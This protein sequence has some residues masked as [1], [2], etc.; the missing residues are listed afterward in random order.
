M[1]AGARVVVVGAG[2]GGSIVADALAERYA[3]TVIELGGPVT[4][5][6]DKI[7]DV[8]YPARLDPHVG[9][10]PGG[11]TGL[12]HNGLIEIDEDVFAERWPFPKAEL[13]P[14]YE[15]AY[16]LLSGATRAFVKAAGEG[17]RG[18]Y[19]DAG[20][21]VDR[22]P[23][24]FVP[25][26][27]RNL[28]HALGVGK[29]VRLVTGE[30]LRL[31]F[32]GAR[33]IRHVV[34]RHEDGERNI[35]GDQFVLAAGGL[36]T[37]PLLQSI[38]R[39]EQLPALRNA[40]RYY[41]DHPMTSVGLLKLRAPLYRFW[42]IAAPGTGGTIRIPLVLRQEGVRVSFQLRPAAM[43]LRDKRRKRV[44]SVI[45]RLRNNPFNPL[46]YFALLRHPDD[47]LDIL[48]FRF[49]IR[50]PTRHYALLMV[51][52]EP[53]SPERAVWGEQDPSGG[54]TRIKRSWRLSKEYFATLQHA[55]ER[56]IG[57]LGELLI[58]AQIFPGWETTLET[59]AHHSGTARM[60]TSPEGGVCNPDGRVHGIDN[61]FVADGSLIP[62]S[63]IANTGLTIA[64]LALRLADH[65][66]GGH[67]RAA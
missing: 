48:S 54:P 64:A 19:R 67:P 10:G 50:V 65:L 12:W 31:V 45:T 35:E 42:N 2:L 30:A 22:S 5:M 7:S 60:S 4:A 61:L 53:P 59:A 33:R 26:T 47:I 27:R 36:G 32:D 58:D 34:V 21:S 24:M 28:W 57:G 52:E 46:N 14:W 63:G 44:R 23:V 6:Q 49:G 66:G 3:V 55:I 25:V 41:E 39:G 40:G 1:S 38:A 43:F 56:F 8:A 20:L 37:P 17:A 16:P 13:E 9:A 51:A 29:R 11:T 15:A 62:G 18:L